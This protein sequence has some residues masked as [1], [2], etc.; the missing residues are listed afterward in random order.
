LGRRHELW[1]RDELTAAWQ[2]ASGDGP[3]D[4][5]VAAASTVCMI[6]TGPGLTAPMNAAVSRLHTALPSR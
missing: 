1:R 2:A 4:R 3:V 5:L 6:T